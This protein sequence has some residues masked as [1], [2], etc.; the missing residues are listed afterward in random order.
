[1]RKAGLAVTV[2][3]SL[4]L[5]GCV[6]T[7]QYADVEFAP[8][9]GDYKLLVMRPDVSVGS[10]TTGGLV[11]PRADWTESAR[12]KLLAALRAQ[13]AGRGGNVMVLDRRDSLAG[14]SADSI[15]ELERLHSAV[16]GSIALHKYSGAT[17]PTKRRK[18]LDYTLG[19]DAVALG[20]RTGYDYAL[21]LHAEDSFASTGRV[22]LQVLGVAGCFVGFCAPNIGLGQ[23]VAYASLVDLR[24]GEVVWFNLLRSQLGDIRT[25]EGAG[26][27]VERLLGRMKP[28]REVRR[29]ER[30]AS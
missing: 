2:A 10:M 12:A 6:S 20:R 3:A 11:E 18:G 4:V 21:F 27:M 23:Q 8:P 26:Q 19:E 13:Q 29:R 16:G 30:A 15:A 1:M 22:A 14:V 9:Q 5:A 24:T 17:L 7:R 25:D 28:G